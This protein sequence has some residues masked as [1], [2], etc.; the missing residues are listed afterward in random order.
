MSNKQ[1]KTQ[2]LCFTIENESSED[3]VEG[4]PLMLFRTSRYNSRIESG[5]CGCRSCQHQFTEQRKGVPVPII[6]SLR[7]DDSAYPK[8]PH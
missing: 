5:C 3:G 4:M 1:A 6:P 8:V 2:T 7:T